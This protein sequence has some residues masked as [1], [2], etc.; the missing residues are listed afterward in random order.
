MPKFKLGLVQ[1]TWFV[2]WDP[3]C[4]QTMIE[5][6]LVL[7]SSWDYAGLNSWSNSNLDTWGSS[8]DTWG[9]S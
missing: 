4:I 7:I 8:L 2:D 6:A 3:W 9:S 5:S 1:S